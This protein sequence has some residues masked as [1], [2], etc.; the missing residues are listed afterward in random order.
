MSG[1]DAAKRKCVINLR[2]N[3]KGL[4]NGEKNDMAWARLN[5]LFL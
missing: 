3:S 5:Y 4:E 1:Q 2:N